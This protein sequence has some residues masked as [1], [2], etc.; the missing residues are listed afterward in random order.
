MLSLIDPTRLRR[1]LCIGAHSD[2]VEIGCGATVLRLLR[3]VPN[4][5]VTWCVLCGGG[6]RGDEA[7]AS[8]ERAGVE[9]VTHAFR[10]AHLPAS[11]A[12]VK[13]AVSD[14]RGLEPDLVFAHRH[15]DA[16]QD[17]RLVAE[18]VDQTFRDHVV[19]GYEIPKFDGDLASQGQPNVFA[20]ASRDDLEAKCRLLDAF[21]SQRDK[22][23][24]DDE[25]FRGL[26]RIRGLECASPTGYAEAFY[27]RKLTF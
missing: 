15:G 7:R 6:V 16:H 9:V 20:Q 2:D 18:L 27:C 23:W 24:F 22:H 12:D 8:A 10:D 17:H 11:W 1:V 19:L 3:V 4:L 14:L 25:T 5:K 13:K 21:A 26:A